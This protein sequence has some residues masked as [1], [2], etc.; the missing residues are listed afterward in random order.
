MTVQ[1]WTYLLV[2]LTFAL[3]IAIA[4]RSRAGSTD[5]FYVAGGGV[6]PLAN[7]M[8]TAADWMSAASFLSMAGLISFTGYDGSV[9]LLG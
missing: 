7:G 3:Y 5:E 2:G 9:Y 8:A 1:T 6:P 4:L